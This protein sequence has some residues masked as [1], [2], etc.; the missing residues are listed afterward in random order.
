MV[1]TLKQLNQAMSSL[2]DVGWRMALGSLILLMFLRKRMAEVFGKRL[3]SSID[4]ITCALPTAALLSCRLNW[5]LVG[6]N[7]RNCRFFSS[8]VKSI[9]LCARTGCLCKRQRATP[10]SLPRSSTC[11]RA[12]QKQ[13]RN[14]RGAL[15]YRSRG[16]TSQAFLRGLL[17]AATG[18]ISCFPPS[19]SV[20][21][22]IRS[23]GPPQ[24]TQPL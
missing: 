10:C 5:A 1:I 24:L 22:L 16:A 14:R 7:I 15:G 11:V 20:P 6:V 13:H 19:W 9:R 4:P 12:A 8:A 18:K 23:R 17:D 2:A 21:F 3:K